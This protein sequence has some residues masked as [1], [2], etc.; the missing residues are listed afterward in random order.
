MNISELNEIIAK[1]TGVSIC[2]ICQVPFTPRHSRQITCASE[3][4]RKAHRKAYLKERKERLME[5]DID[6]WR[7]KRAAAQRKHRRKKKGLIVADENL[8]RAQE[9]W[10]KQEAKHYLAISDGKEYAERQMADTLAKVP[11]ID[12]SGFDRK[13]GAE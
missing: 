2:P 11:K 12:V 6:L 5:E 13:D 1:E 10:E 4:C 9:Y 3:E 7:A 8:K